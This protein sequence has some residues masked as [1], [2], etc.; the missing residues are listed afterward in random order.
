MQRLEENILHYDLHYIYFTPSQYMSLVL[1]LSSVPEKVGINKKGVNQKLYSHEKKRCQS[2]WA[3]GLRYLSTDTH[4]LGLWVR[5]SFGHASWM[6]VLCECRV[7]SSRGLC[8]RLITHPEQS[9]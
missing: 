6:Y 1:G 7:L 2:W 3:C 8:I 5:I 4:L 9:Y